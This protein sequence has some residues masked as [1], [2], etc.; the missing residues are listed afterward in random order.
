MAT[1]V[2]VVNLVLIAAGITFS[3]VV[4][5]IAVAFFTVAVAVFALMMLVRIVPRL[6]R[7]H[8]D[9]GFTAYQHYGGESVHSTNVVH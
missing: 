9:R 6:D 2:I 4:E 5:L 3:P 1:L 8:V 7:I